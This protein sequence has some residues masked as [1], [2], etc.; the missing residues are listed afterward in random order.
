MTA[1]VLRLVADDL[2]GALDTA[3]EFTALCGPVPVRWGTEE[4]PGSFAVTIATREA[5]REVAVLRGAEAAGLLAGADIAFHKIDSLLRGNVAAELAAL[6]AVGGWR[7]VVLAPA[8]PAQ[9]RVTRDGWQYALEPGR[10]ARPVA[11]KLSAMLTAEGLACSP[12]DPGAELAPGISVFDAETEEDL[13]RIVAAGR[14]DSG[15]VLWCGSGGLGRALAAAHPARAET[16]L[17]G[18]VLGLFGSDQPAT[19]RQLAACGPL[20][21]TLGPPDRAAAALA[22]R[23][24]ALVDV[25]LPPDLPRAEAARRIASAFAALVI[26]LEPPGTLIVAGG[27]TLGALCGALAARSLEARGLVAPGVPRSV[28]RGGRWD[29]VEV[30]SKSGAFG[31]DALWRDLLAVNGFLPELQVT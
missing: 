11:S 31:G 28:I 30:V 21:V 3:A 8:F 12:G 6:V 1:P 9:G 2:T 7:S 20:R 19:A 17:R 18:P 13:L 24:A 23:G 22:E 14:T 5:A 29:G 4:T 16:T 25:D 26:R 10:A 15:P 27:E